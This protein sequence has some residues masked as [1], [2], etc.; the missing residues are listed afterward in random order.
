MS[1]IKEKYNKTVIAA[2]TEKFGYKNKMAVPKIEKVVVNVG[3]GRGLSDSKF[4]QVVEDTL[5]RITG[6]KPVKGSAKKSIS[7]FKIRAGQTVGMTVTLRG[8]TM[9]HFIDKLVNITLPRVRDFRGLNHKSVDSQG[10]LNI[11]FTEHIAFPEIKSDEVE[12]IHGLEVAVVTS[13]KTKEEGLE[14]LTLLGFPFQKQ[15]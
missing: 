4:N 8:Q 1:R 15:E 5:Q 12:K 10:N 13:A 7:N 9:D 2:L 6:Q 11:G 3:T 14:L